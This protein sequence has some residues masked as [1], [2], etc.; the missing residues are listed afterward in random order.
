MLVLAR[1]ESLEPLATG[2]LFGSAVTTCGTLTTGARFP[3]FLA[4]GGRLP[5]AGLEVVGLGPFAEQN[6]DVRICKI[7]T[8]KKNKKIRADLPDPEL[9]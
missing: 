6:H 9:Q 4:S 1:T 2:C 5:G 3:Q 7:G 8:K